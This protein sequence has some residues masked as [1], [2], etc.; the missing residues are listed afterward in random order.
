M[1]YQSEAQLEEQLVERLVNM[2]YERVNVKDEVSLIHNFRTQLNKHNKDRLK[3]RD[4]SDSE[5]DRLMQLISNKGV[6]DSAKILRNLQNITRDDGTVLYLELF[7]KRDWCKNIFQ[8]A[9]QITIQGKYENRYDVTILING[10]PLVQIELKRRGGNTDEAFHQITRYQL[11]SYKYTKLFR[12]IQIFVI[13]NGTDTKYLGN[14]GKELSSKYTFYWT[15]DKNNRYNN[16]KEFTTFFLEKCHIAKMI[17]RYT[18]IYES[19]KNL[20]VLRPYQVYAV[21]AIIHRVENSNRN[22]YIWHTTGSGKTLTSFKASQILQDNEKVDQIFF[23]VDRRDLDSQTIEEFNKFCPDSIDTTNSTNQLVKQI[24]DNNKKLIVTTIQKLSNAVKKYPQKLGQ[25]KDKRVVFIIDE[26]HRSQFGDMHK[27]ID[28][29]FDNAQYF[30]FTGTPRFSVNKSI[31]GRSTA[32]IFGENLHSYL[33]KDAIHDGNVLGFKVEYYKSVDWREEGAIEEKVEGINTYEILTSE[34]RTRNIVEEIVKHHDMKTV[35]R[36]FNAMF[37]VNTS[38]GGVPLLYQYYNQFQE[39]NKELDKPL[40]I[41]AIFSYAA[42]SQLQEDYKNETG[43]KI[44]QRDMLQN[45]IDDYNVMFGTNYS[46][47][48]YLQ[49][50][51]DLSKRVKNTEI[52]ILLVVDM[53]LTGFDARRLN[54]LYVD[55]NLRYHTLIQAYSRTNR[56]YDATKQYGNIVCFQNLKK[57]TDDAIKLFSQTEDVNNVLMKEYAYYVEEFKN[58]YIAFKKIVPTLDSIDALETDDQKAKFI[59]L[60]KLLARTA[61]S[62]K[63]FNEFD[64]KDV[65]MN[66]QEFEDYKGRYYELTRKI[67]KDKVSVLQE[68]DFELELIRTDKIDVGYILEL[69]QNIELT[70]RTKQIKDIKNILEIL[71]T[72]TD[73]KLRSKRELIEMFLEKV[74][75][76]LNEDDDISFKLEEFESEQ[77]LY[78]MKKLSNKYDLDYNKVAA[79]VAEQEFVGYIDGTKVIQDMKGGLLEKSKKKKD[80]VQDIESLGMK[81]E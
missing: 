62:L 39:K 48:T 63:T 30:G 20:M 71:K 67:E 26:C 75:P 56:I 7:N 3:N 21:E 45:I 80:F 2:G 68:I 38:E 42:N 72:A 5:F 28:M 22:G 15:D 24:N 59:R 55:R 44:H 4:L 8:V 54:T 41:G 66:E 37:T 25:Y 43:E 23:L 64:W 47:D 40:K 35:N 29:Y 79:Y 46:T 6:Y 34:E 1:G 27:E 77:K 76:T 51:I 18:V 33:I 78:E 65:P 9:N 14:S 16:L 11:H 60:F 36:T 74:V 57:N 58:A 49:Y 70:D 19:E 81:Y 31:D 32:D 53:F 13:S 10:L 12:F 50:F 52:D 61:I 17:A 69:I 73:E